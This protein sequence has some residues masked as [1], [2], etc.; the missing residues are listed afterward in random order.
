MKVAVGS[1][2]D[3]RPKND[4]RTT[5]KEKEDEPSNAMTR[6]ELSNRAGSTARRQTLCKAFRFSIPHTV[7]HVFSSVYKQSAYFLLIREG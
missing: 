4:G 5:N 2:L 3:V 1:L 7:A 6:K